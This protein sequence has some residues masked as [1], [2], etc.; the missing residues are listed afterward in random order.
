MERNGWP[1]SRGI[2]KLSHNSKKSVTFECLID[3]Q[4][5][6]QPKSLEN[7]FNINPAEKVGDIC[8]ANAG[9]SALR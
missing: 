7:Q 4:V 8:T 3:I 5:H 9:E 2:S 6:S 1:K